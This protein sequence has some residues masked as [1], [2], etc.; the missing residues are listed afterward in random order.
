MFELNNTEN[1]VFLYGFNSL[2]NLI[3][4]HFIFRKVSIFEQT[5]SFSSKVLLSTCIPM[6]WIILAEYVAIHGPQLLLGAFWPPEEVAVFSICLR[7][8]TLISFILTSASRVVAP[9]IAILHS[10]EDAKGLAKLASITTIVMLCFASILSLGI[11]I[12]SEE[13][14]GLFGSE[15]INSRHILQLFALVQLIMV[16]FGLGKIVLQ[17]SGYERECKYIVFFNALLIISF[18]FVFIPVYSSFG[19]VLSLLIAAIISTGITI[20]IIKK[21]LDFYLVGLA[22]L[23]QKRKLKI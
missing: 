13:L 8:A 16:V 9:K 4:C 5:S 15:Y 14:L 1:M 3:V 10:N 18:C 19:A 21:K 12:F 20:M 23:F 22:W 2:L 17:M 7:I 6:F 11:I